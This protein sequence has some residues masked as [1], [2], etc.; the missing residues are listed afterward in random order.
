MTRQE[1]NKA[2]VVRWFTDFWG[3]SCDLSVVDDIA[4]PDMLLKYSLHEPR[5]GRD[6][7]K[8]FMSGF[9]AA[10]P[11]L[12]FWA[13]ADLIAE[14]DYVVGQWEGGGTHT[15][16]AFGDFLAGSLPAATGRTMRFTG[17]TVLKVVDGRIVEEIG[18][19]DGV[20]ALTQL[21]LIKVA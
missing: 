9:R 8:A 16:P 14:G 21:G 6:D 17:T 12:N 10:F 3:E 15:G 5:R 13:T 20:A 11:D 1:D 2:V 19:D 18:L 7:I 4:A